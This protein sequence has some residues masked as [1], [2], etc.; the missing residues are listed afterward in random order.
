MKQLLCLLLMSVV[1]SLGALN[2]Q[3]NPSSADSLYTRV[4]S[5]I[6][7]KKAEKAMELIKALEDSLLM[8]DFEVDNILLSYKAQCANLTKN[9]ALEEACYLRILNSTN[10]LDSLRCEANF[11]LSTCYYF[12]GKLEEARNRALE[13]RDCNLKRYG[14]E[15]KLFIR[16]LNSLG[17][18]SKEM[19]H[20]KEAEQYFLEAKKLNYR[21]SK[22]QDLQYARIIN[23]LGDVY[24][25]WQRFDKAEELYKTSL[26]IKDHLGLGST[27][28]YAKTLFNLSKL[29]FTI[30]KY[31]FAQAN[32]DEAIEKST[33]GITGSTL[34]MQDLRAIILFRS[35][36]TEEAERTLR[37]LID[38]REEHGMTGMRE[39][40]LSMMSLST[41][42]LEH[43]RADS[44]IKYTLKAMDAFV[45]KNNP[46]HVYY[47]SMLTTLG[48][49]ELV[50]EDYPSAIQH[51]EQASV[52]FA[53]QLGR[54][55]MDF[56]TNQ[57]HYARALR[58]IGKISRAKTMYKEIDDI[59]KKYLKRVSKFLSENELDQ[60]TGKI[61]QYHEEIYSLN[62]QLPADADLCG[63]SYNNALFYKGY[64]QHNLAS[65]RKNLS[66]TTE[67]IDLRER[68]LE[69]QELL[70][71]IQKGEG[72][73]GKKEE[74]V[75][76][77]IS[78]TEYELQSKLK[79]LGVDD[80][81]TDW[82]EVQEALGQKESAVEFVEFEESGQ[83]EYA[84]VILNH[85]APAPMYITLTKESVVQELIQ[86]RIIPWPMYIAGIYNYQKRAMI[87][88]NARKVS[89]YDILWKPLSSVIPRGNTIYYSATGWMHRIA[90]DAVPVSYTE[91]LSDLYDL[92]QLGSTRFLSD[93]AEGSGEEMPEEVLLV[94]GLRYGDPELRDE[95]DHGTW[96]YL[97][98]TRAEVEGIGD[99]CRL[100]Q[101]PKVIMMG[102]HAT[103]E[104]LTEKIRS[105]AQ[106]FR[107]IHLSTH[108]YFRKE[109]DS[110]GYASRGRAG[111]LDF[112][113]SGIVLSGAGRAGEPGTDGIW[114][115][116]EIER[117][118]LKRTGLVVLSACETG[119]GS[120]RTQ[121]GV[122]GLQRAFRIAGAGAL[123]MSLWQ[124]P[125]QETHDFM[126]RF[127]TNYLKEKR[128]LRESFRLTQQEM[129]Q[130]FINPE[131]WAGFVLVE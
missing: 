55:H 6:R 3:G 118:D 78:H 123:I 129:R 7:E 63:M 103:E 98:W 57:F 4:K 101:I 76:S 100:A 83:N 16:C 106:G 122:Y 87:E 41:L 126:L 30:G 61:R 27:V 11:N 14:E 89:L 72:P 117:L 56:F 94:G 26:Q 81:Q 31:G 49:A 54:E 127:Y 22:G 84:A 131:Q 96:P 68:W 35:G 42:F 91:N 79:L 125:D 1:M 5:L 33:A 120:I 34:K 15:H 18:F 53:R 65:L 70:D 23:N 17:Q 8:R 28:E 128:D 37:R 12:L 58:K 64:I 36:K 75:R 50:K 99:I 80:K 93:K 25:T 69:Q 104:Q 47:A 124:I 51:Y 115:V 95:E 60:L 110:L 48:D 66:R 20:L 29:Y 88:V 90:H 102:D 77:V 44:C 43:G 86:P 119:L 67:I 105:S 62:K 92:R 45:K 38:Y 71:L 19:S 59:P 112:N 116:A 130:R 9:Y 74:E 13:A 113:E 97:P 46:D 2:G 52:I 107:L 21:I 114:S 111:G 24:T 73:K 32:I 121:E 109:R 10:L 85:N 82:K 108:A 39:Y 40:P